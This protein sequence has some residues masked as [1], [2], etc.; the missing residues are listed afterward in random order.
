METKQTLDII[1]K[2]FR[3]LELFGEANIK[4][5][6]MLTYLMFIDEYYEY[7]RNVSLNDIDNDE[8]G[9]T[10]CRVKN[11][12]RALECLK[13]NSD[14]LK[15]STLDYL[16]TKIHWIIPDTS[17]DDDE[18]SYVKHSILYTVGTV[19]NKILEIN[20]SVNNHILEV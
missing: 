7:Y 19:S 2:Y 1:G 15:C 8:I 6:M 12:N 5:L 10:D 3:R 17:G 16:P 11:L 4:E 13:F 9:L 20:K 18:Q 14:I